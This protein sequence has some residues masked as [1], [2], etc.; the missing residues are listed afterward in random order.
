MYINI[1]N[2]RDSFRQRLSR[3]GGRADDDLVQSNLSKTTVLFK[4][5]DLETLKSPG[6]I[7]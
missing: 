2:R 1:L 7:L 5:H 4:F 6:G 3:V